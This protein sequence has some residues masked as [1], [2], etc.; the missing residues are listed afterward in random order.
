MT[1]IH[2]KPE[3]SSVASNR[4]TLLFVCC[5]GGCLEQGLCTRL[6]QRIYNDLQEFEIHYQLTKIH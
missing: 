4:S 5:W 3:C 1:L 2:D 6:A